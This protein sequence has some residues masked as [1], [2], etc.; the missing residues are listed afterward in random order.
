MRDAELI[1][2]TRVPIGR[3]LAS[4]SKHKSILRGTDC[5]GRYKSGVS[6]RKTELVHL[7]K[8]QPFFVPTYK[9][10]AVLCAVAKNIRT[11]SVVPPFIF[12]GEHSS[13]QSSW[14]L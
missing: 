14:K 8:Q 9:T 4:P 3:R 12:T 10:K 6:I 11:T 5:V 1:V 7:L 13:E 2:E